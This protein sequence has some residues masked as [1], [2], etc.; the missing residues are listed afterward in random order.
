MLFKV[1]YFCYFLTWELRYLNAQSLCI[2]SSYYTIYIMLYLCP[3]HSKQNSFQSLVILT[4]FRSLRLQIELS[5]V[6]ENFV[7]FA[8]SFFALAAWIWFSF[9]GG[10]AFCLSV[11]RAFTPQWACIQ[12]TRQRESGWE[13]EQWGTSHRLY[14]FCCFFLDWLPQSALSSSCSGTQCTK[15][16][17]EKSVKF[18]KWR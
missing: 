14:Y 11:C 15:V 10:F 12:W 13:G 6:H 1:E 9:L 4:L 7:S 16:C 2:I 5:W 17:D 18:E 8:I 3:R